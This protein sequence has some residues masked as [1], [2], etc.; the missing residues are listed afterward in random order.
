VDVASNFNP[1][2]ALY[3]LG[4]KALGYNST[5]QSIQNII[6]GKGAFDNPP[7]GF[8]TDLIGGANASSP[9]QNMLTYDPVA[10]YQNGVQFIPETTMGY[11]P[12]GNLTR[13][14]YQKQYGGRDVP[15]IPINTTPKTPTTPTTPDTT[16]SDT[17]TNGLGLATYDPRT[18]LGGVNDPLTYG[19]GGEQVYYKAM[20]GAVGPLSQKRK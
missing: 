8:L 11:G 5:G 13:E 6:D 3:N 1:L 12:Y 2:T 10:S 15:V 19:F 14:E 17:P 9:N 20:G 4:G 18:Y 7:E 16:T